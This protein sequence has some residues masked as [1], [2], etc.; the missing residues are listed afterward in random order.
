M[1]FLVTRSWTMSWSSN[2]G[3]IKTQRRDL[4]SLPVTTAK[5]KFFLDAYS[6]PH[7]SENTS[8]SKP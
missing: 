2:I 6:A 4:G 5:T 1:G 3:R 7:V 8:T